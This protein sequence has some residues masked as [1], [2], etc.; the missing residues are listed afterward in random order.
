M[1][2]HCRMNEQ[3]TAVYQGWRRPGGA[4]W[5]TPPRPAPARRRAA[6]A[7]AAACAPAG[8]PAAW[9]A[10]E[11]TGRRSPRR[12]APRCARRRRARP[13][14]RR[15]GAATQRPSA[16]APSVTPRDSRAQRARQGPARGT[17][18]C[19]SACQALV[20]PRARRRRSTRG[21]DSAAGADKSATCGTQA[22]L[23]ARNVYKHLGQEHGLPPRA[24]TCK[25]SFGSQHQRLIIAGKTSNAHIA[26]TCLHCCTLVISAV[27]GTLLRACLHGLLPCTVAGRQ[28]IRLRM[29][30][31]RALK[32]RWQAVH[33]RASPIRQVYA[34][35]ASVSLRKADAPRSPPAPSAAKQPELRV[36]TR[37]CAKDPGLSSHTYGRKAI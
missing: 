23:C 18:A 34:H 4:T 35:P 5:R 32:Q 37:L 1:F 20:D 36:R 24:Q 30:A 10:A 22:L 7:R 9:A 6:R 28:R 29:H 2:C 12:P 26:L 8:R 17:E 15:S 27:S 33:L 3:I 14:A 21:T 25:Q 19:A 11:S 16:A 31:A 13:R